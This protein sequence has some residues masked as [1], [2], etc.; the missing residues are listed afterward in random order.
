LSARE[1]SQTLR[2]LAAEDRHHDAS[3]CQEPPASDAA[4]QRKAS[5]HAEVLQDDLNANV[6]SLAASTGLADAAHFEYIIE[7]LWSYFHFFCQ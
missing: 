3:E 1:S 4:S 2:Q 5:I 6:R 7:F